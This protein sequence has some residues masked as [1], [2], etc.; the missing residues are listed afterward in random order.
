MPVLASVTDCFALTVPRACW[1][2]EIADG[3]RLATGSPPPVP[4]K[5]TVWGLLIALSVMASDAP[6]DPVAAGVNV[7]LIV[8]LAPAATLL[9]QVF[10]WA[11]SPGFGPPMAMLEMFREA[12]PM[13]ESVTVC[14]ELVVPVFCWLKVRLAGD[15]DTA[16]AGGGGLLPPLP[17]PPPQ[18]TQTPTTRSAIAN[19]QPAGRRRAVAKLTSMARPSKPAN[20]QSHAATDGP[21]PGG[22]FRS[23]VGSV[24]LGAA[25]VVTVS[26]AVAPE[27]PVTVTDD[28]ENVQPIL[29]SEAPQLKAIDPVKPATGVKVT[30]E[31][32]DCP[33][34][35]IVMLLG[36][37]E[38]LKSETFIVTAGDVVELR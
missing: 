7:T 27:G 2:K 34:A 35:G 28:G 6:R 19:S 37:A 32:P 14:G 8:Q 30:V 23:S 3:K 10:V 25:A 36:L 33:G 13:F 15:N 18:A 17:P 11:K 4:L 29:M 22:V 24:A 12:L 9:P 21:K 31:V 38:T 16:G 1:P 20:A 5:L 26:V